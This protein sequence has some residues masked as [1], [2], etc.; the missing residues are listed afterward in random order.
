MDTPGNRSMARRRRTLRR[1][2]LM[3]LGASPERLAEQADI[4]AVIGPNLTQEQSERLYKLNWKH[5]HSET[6]LQ[7]W[8][9]HE[10]QQLKARRE[11]R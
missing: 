2:D 8:E 3:V 1:L 9:E 5:E 6:P 11:G 10:R 4:P 7:P